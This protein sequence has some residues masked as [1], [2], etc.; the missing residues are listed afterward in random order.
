MAHRL[1]F[2]RSTRALVQR[3][4][5]LF[6]LSAIGPACGEEEGPRPD[7]L[8]HVA[9]PDWS[10][11]IIYFVLIDRFNDGDPSNNDQGAGEYDPSDFTRYSGGDLQGIIDRLDYI[12]GLG[13]TAVWITPPVANLWWDPLSEFSGYHGYWG[14][15]FKEV[16]EH[17]GTLETYQALSRALHERGMFLIQDVVPNH[18][19]NFFTWDGPYDPEDPTANFLLNGQ[20]VP[21][22]A[23]EQ[24]PF[25]MN[26]VTNAD[27][28]TAAV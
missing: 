13:A 27:H 18:T 4:V 2:R 10:E 14:R 11:Q 1:S 25:D 21:T 7:P 3:L 26:D 8:L 16:D 23:P 24:A 9:S 15:H 20:A 19:G 22:A 5:A 12:Q 6:A 28:R 17:Y